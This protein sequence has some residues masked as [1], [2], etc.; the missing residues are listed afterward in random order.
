MPTPEVNECSYETVFNPESGVAVMIDPFS[1]LY[2][3]LFCTSLTAAFAAGGTRH[4]A[5]ARCYVA[6]AVIY[7]LLGV[8]H[9]MHL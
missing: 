1:L 4:G 3:S 2:A 7:L 8:C 6:N 9:W 5:L